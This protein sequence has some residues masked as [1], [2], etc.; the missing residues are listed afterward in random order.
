MSDLDKKTIYLHIGISKTGTTSIQRFLYKNQETL[1]TKGLLYPCPFN[2]GSVK[3]NK[4]ECKSNLSPMATEVC[5]NIGEK[6]LYKFKREFIRWNL[7]VTPEERYN[8]YKEGFE[9]Y[10]LD[11]IN[12]SDCEKILLSEEMFTSDFSLMEFCDVIL[13]EGFDLKIIV[14]LRNTPEYIV[15]V[16]GQSVKPGSGH[17]FYLFDDLLKLP[18]IIYD[19]D[20][21]L[22]VEKLG[23][24]NVIIRT[25]EKSCWK[26]NNLL[27]DFM[28]CL[29]FEL[30]DDYFVP[31]KDAN[32][33]FDR[34]TVE[35]ASII[36]HLCLS[37]EGLGKCW[38]K[39]IDLPQDKRK[40]IETFSDE[41]IEYLNKN[42]APFLKD[43]AVLYGKE[44][45]F[46][47]EYPDCYGKERPI[48]DKVSFTF[49]KMDI[50]RDALTINKQEKDELKQTVSELKSE[51][52]NLNNQIHDLSGEN[53]NL[54]NRIKDLYT[55][56]ENLN[57][58]IRDLYS[59]KEKYRVLANK[60]KIRFNYHKCR[61][62][63]NL[64]FGNLKQHYVDKK[65]RLKDD[66]SLLNSI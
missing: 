25:F 47:N 20:L 17:N 32:V 22:L 19:W 61:L 55:E 13:D 27:V 50:L 43:V 29:G 51:I 35:L 12:N 18:I 45:L 14:Y 33:S 31:D 63:A 26:N 57:N 7:D 9:K 39:I 30:T 54:N 1:K 48:Y 8:A 23:K 44:S 60:N 64:T 65:H 37:D 56:T 58:H 11:L 5:K 38:D 52:E 36:N 40:L 49:D 24:E 15:S 4:E 62:L 42:F 2:I 28:D 16:W 21:K 66:F 6:E 46:E 3:F 34:D 10:Y 41:K 59:E 53:Q